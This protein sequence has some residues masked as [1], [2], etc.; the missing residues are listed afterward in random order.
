MDL[1]YKSTEYGL[2][3]YDFL[4]D[5]SKWTLKVI[6]KNNKK[7][8]NMSIRDWAKEQIIIYF[9][10][11]SKHRPDD[12]QYIVSN[13]SSLFEEMLEQKLIEVE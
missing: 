3:F 2:H 6:I 9:R 1:H 7:R 12:H 4:G 10:D 11:S 13:I 8:E 5:Q